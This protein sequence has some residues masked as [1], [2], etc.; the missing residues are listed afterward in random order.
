M[1]EDTRLCTN[2]STSLGV[3]EVRKDP[4]VLVL[5]VVAHVRIVH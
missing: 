3:F 2:G 1:M 4:V 5:C